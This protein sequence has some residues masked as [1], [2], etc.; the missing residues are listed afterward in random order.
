MET[1]ITFVAIITTPL[2]HTWEGKQFIQRSSSNVLRY[3]SGMVI[4]WFGFLENIDVPILY[5][6]GVVLASSVPKD[7]Q[8]I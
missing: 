1:N 4:Y 6:Q 2:H 8:L 7:I 3:G 5:D